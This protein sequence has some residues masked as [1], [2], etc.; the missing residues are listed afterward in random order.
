MNIA[1]FFLIEKYTFSLQKC[2]QNNERKPR[3]K[4]I[5]L[6]SHLTFFLLLI[7]SNSSMPLFRNLPPM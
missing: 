7:L 5:H 1:Y 4:I 2:I 6:I 3:V